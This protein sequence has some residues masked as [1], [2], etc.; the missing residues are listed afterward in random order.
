V[1]L[2]PAFRWL[3]YTA[4]DFPVAETAAAEVLSLP[5]YPGITAAQQER[6][7]DEL[8]KALRAVGGSA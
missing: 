6:V 2:Q 4:G 5:L 3:G 1:H 8:V 7:I